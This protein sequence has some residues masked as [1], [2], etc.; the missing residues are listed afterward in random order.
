MDCSI[1]NKEEFFGKSVTVTDDGNII[2]G[3]TIQMINSSIQ[4]KG[5]NNVLFLDNVR[6]RDS[7]IK[8]LGNNSVVFLSE[9][10]YEY[11][12]D[13]SIYNDSVF[14]MG[15]NNFINQVMTIVLSEQK[16]CFIGDYG[17]FSRDIWIRN[18]DA[19]LIYDAL[20]Q[21]RLN[22]SKSIY[23]GDHVWLGQNVYILKGTQIDSGSIIGAMS[24]VSG[25]KIP[26]NSAWAGNPCKKVREHVF[27]DSACVH[28]YTEEKTK[29]SRD[30]EKFIATKKTEC[31]TDYWIYQYNKLECIDWEI[32][33]N[34]FSEKFSSMD[35]FRFLIQF[36]SE[37][38]KNR[39]T[40]RKG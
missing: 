12:L 3:S 18:A 28:G 27:W 20:D 33:E 32:L 16:H 1:T 11:K 10:K 40:H 14:H 19:H 6:L 25:K 22:Y 35:K 9:N 17:M 30:Y 37:K 5:K 26:H 7:N 34:N 21:K 4:F 36:N 8:F 15:M 13:V 38:E 29:S 23:I 24:V 39:F 31:H 2:I